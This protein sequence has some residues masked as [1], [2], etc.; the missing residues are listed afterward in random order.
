MQ[1]GTLLRSW[2]SS[3]STAACTRDQ[4]PKSDRFLHHAQN[5]K[6]Q[7]ERSHYNDWREGC[8]HGQETLATQQWI[9]LAA[10]VKRSV[11]QEMSCQSLSNS[12][13][14]I[15]YNE[16]KT[17]ALNPLIASLQMSYMLQN[18]RL[19]PRSCWRSPVFRDVTPCQ[20]TSISRSLEGPYYLHSFENADKCSP[21]NIASHLGRPES[22]SNTFKTWNYIFLELFLTP[23]VESFCK[24][25]FSWISDAKSRLLCKV[26]QKSPMTGRH[27]D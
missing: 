24:D 8:R 11:E 16:I 7:H 1:D 15:L 10:F 12:S 23:N 2:R 5:N 19:S 26:A 6:R 25:I 13:D 21:N 3:G 18:W 17:P 22:T 20:W 9:E 14:A 27:G 4:K